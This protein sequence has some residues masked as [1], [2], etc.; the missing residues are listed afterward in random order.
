MRL[1][2]V[3]SAVHVLAILGCCFP[4][5]TPEEKAAREAERAVEEQKVEAELVTLGQRLQAIHAGVTAM[6]TPQESRCDDAKVAALVGEK[7]KTGSTLKW[8]HAIMVRADT[9]AR[10]SG[11]ALFS[12]PKAGARERRRRPPRG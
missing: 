5:A 10:F 8:N 12:R 3:V 11:G 6:G 7:P 9:L 4:T 1:L 2:P